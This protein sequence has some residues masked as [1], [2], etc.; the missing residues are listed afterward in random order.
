MYMSLRKSISQKR[1]GVILLIVLMMLVLFAIVGITFVLMADARSTEARIYREAQN[2]TPPSGIT[3]AN[4]APTTPSQGSLVPDLQLA[5]FLNRL[6]YDDQDDTYGISDGM[7]GLSLARGMYSGQ[8]GNSAAYNGVGRVR[9]GN[10]TITD[11]QGNQLFSGDPYQLAHY[12]YFSGQS[13]FVDPEHQ[14]P[15]SNVSSPPAANDVVQSNVACTYPDLNN[16]FLACANSDGTVTMRSFF[17]D[18]LY[19]NGIYG[20]PGG[21]SVLDPNN[22][23]WTNAQGKY[24]INRPRPVDM[25]PGFPYPA[26]M[27]G[28]V[29][30]LENGPGYFDIG[31]G[32][33]Y[34][35]DSMWMD[36]NY[37]IIKDPNT[38][39]LYKPLFAPLILDVA[40]LVNLN[41][42]GNIRNQGNQAQLT[43]ASNHGLA[44]SEVNLQQ[45]LTNLTNPYEVSQLFTGASGVAGRYG[46]WTGAPAAV[47]IPMG[48]APSNL[49][50]GSNTPHFYANVD[51]DGG[52]NAQ[53]SNPIVTSPANPVLLPGATGFPTLTPS[54]QG[55]QFLAFP[56]FPAN[57]YLSGW[58]FNSLEQK[59]HPALF[60]AFAP[61]T[62]NSVFP[63]AEMESIMR[64]GQANTPT[65]RILQLLPLTLVND[66]ADASSNVNTA[67][68]R[69]LVTLLS[70][71]V[72]KA[73]LTPWLSSNNPAANGD[74]ALQ[75]NSNF[76]QGGSAKFP[77]PATNA[78]FEFNATRGGRDASLGRVDLD[79][80]LTS[81]PVADPTTGAFKAA[82]IP[83]Y[84]AAVQARQLLAKDI[85]NRLR[86]VTTG[87][88]T[89]DPYPKVGTPEY[90]AHR[91]LAQLAVNIVDF[92][93]SDE[94]STP[95]HWDTNANLPNPGNTTDTTNDQGWVF[96]TKLPRVLV[97]EVYAQAT[98]VPG[99]K[100]G[101]APTQ[102]NLNLWAELHNP[103]QTEPPQTD[104]SGKNIENRNNDKWDTNSPPNSWVRLQA[105]NPQNNQTYAI[106]KLEITQNNSNLTAVTNVRG[107]P[108]A[109]SLSEVTGYDKNSGVPSGNCDSTLIQPANGIYGG[110]TNTNNGNNVGFYLLGPTDPANPNKAL[111]FPQGSP[112]NADS[113]ALPQSTFASPEMN[114][115]NIA[116][117]PQTVSVLLRRLA[118]PAMPLNIDPTSASYNP[119]ITVDYV[120]NVSVNDATTFNGA[121]QPQTPNY[122]ALYSMGK[123]E[124]YAAAKLQAQNQLANAYTD[125]PQHT[126]FRQNATVDTPP[127]TAP[128]AMLTFPFHWLSQLNRSVISAMELTQVS[129]FK[130]HLLTQMFVT[131]NGPYQHT[132]NWFDPNLRI[133]RA[134]EFLE[135]A[136]RMAGSVKGG[137]YLARV[138]INSV[139]DL[140]TFRALCDAQSPNYFSGASST[141]SGAVTAGTNTITVGAF[142]GS[143]T[144]AGKQTTWQILPQDPI[145]L[146]VPG[147][148]D[149]E[150]VT[151]QSANFSNGSWT[152]TTA[153]PVQNNHA[154]NESVTLELVR[155]FFNRMI[156]ARDNPQGMPA[157]PGT[158]FQSYAQGNIP[159]GDTQYPTGNGIQNTILQASAS[160]GRMFEITDA[161]HPYYHY[162]LM[163]KIFDR[164]TTRSNSFAVWVTVGYFPVTNAA[165]LSPGQTQNG[166]GLPTIQLGPEITD[167]VTGLVTRHK[168]FAVLDRSA[169]TFLTGQPNLPGPAPIFIYGRN[170]NQNNLVPTTLQVDGLSGQS[171]GVSFT[172]G[173][174]TTLI[175]D[176]G[177]ENEEQ[178][179]VMGTGTQGGQPTIQ[180]Q[181]TKQHSLIMPI[182][183][184]DR[185]MGNPGPQPGNFDPRTVGGV[186]KYYRLVQ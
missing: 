70:P 146:N 121:G 59:N 79:R 32:K 114:V 24:L 8:A 154:N 144:D 42:H 95:F 54:T 156:A 106:Y 51:A 101:Q 122:S 58:M 176:E 31:T 68:R 4:T 50:G 15:R 170:T 37:P 56:W 72:D 137:R 93:N 17:R 89:T 85:F 161:P 2:A 74:Y 109:K 129:A 61:I 145:M 45:V 162:E 34:T 182:T 5:Y 110:L 164:I 175:I 102:F 124:P 134:F 49:A 149:F 97:N 111:A 69:R 186:V 41:V 173:K 127:V 83:Q 107:S 48:N 138:N 67:N 64:Y 80:A 33:H 82:D 76:P 46:T 147:S 135:A 99:Q 90:E 143:G 155:R 139:R 181:A 180:I 128:D 166:F 150:L 108:D 148:A 179:T 28:D 131:A 132:A 98:N 118:C 168:M 172:I 43:S 169:L 19:A 96:G 57:T 44:A 81:Y 117:V 23:N 153:S 100:N 152:I 141:L 35:N 40:G 142:K 123:M 11:A 87:Y 16:S 52:T 112:N 133:Y 78:T 9:G 77:S 115:S 21:A 174:G 160:G 94:Y 167:P 184:A 39:I 14:N 158:P 86:S 75:N 178:V 27:G 36:I 165:Q 136:D 73:G 171:E 10:I 12:M 91:W 63:I 66:P 13:S 30:N 159:A 183:L 157:G 62:P 113:R 130:P 126:F 20:A 3:D 26:D 140:Q 38:G 177:R 47:P 116:S 55:P 151:V 120:Q 65:S 119:Y 1:R 104:S 18:Y 71:E 25:G 29:Q 22:P 7:R 105:T 125:R 163:N 84:Q 53:T 185:R 6:I 60:G 88:T 92:V 103:M